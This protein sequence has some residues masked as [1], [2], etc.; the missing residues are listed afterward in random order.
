MAIDP[1][2][3]EP[4]ADVADPVVDVDFGAA[5]AQRRFT[6]HRHALLALASWQ[7]A[8][9]D[10]THLLWGPTREPLVDEAIIVALGIAR[11][12][13]F[14]SV[15]VLANA[16]FEDI[17]VRRGICSHQAVPSWGMGLYVVTLLS[18]VSPAQSPP[19]SACCTEVRSPTSLPCTT[20]TAGQR[21]NANSYTI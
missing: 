3:L 20:G 14:T 16:L 21:Q 9:C 15:P 17:P 12:E 5:Q 8:L 10:I 7:T 1:A 2:L 13:A 6:A 18:H 11:R 19:A 4:L